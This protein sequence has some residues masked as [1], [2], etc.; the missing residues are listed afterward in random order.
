MS[1][2]ESRLYGVDRHWLLPLESNHTTKNGPVQES[3]SV[4]E[5]TAGLNGFVGFFPKSDFA[6]F[7]TES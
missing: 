1:N 7:N 5:S 2:A 6:V 3:C 4:L